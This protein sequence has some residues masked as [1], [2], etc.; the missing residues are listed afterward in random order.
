MDSSKYSSANASSPSAV[1]SRARQPSPP[2]SA[3]VD[4][5]RRSTR[6]AEVIILTKCPLDRSPY[7]PS[8]Y[9]TLHPKELSF[10]SR[11]R[12]N[13]RQASKLKTPPSV[14]DYFHLNSIM[15]AFCRRAPLIYLTPSR[16]P[17]DKKKWRKPFWEKRN[18]TF[19]RGTPSKKLIYEH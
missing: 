4:A 14:I 9:L 10:R 5:A 8:L 15:F 3:A 18:S 11:K 19:S 12:K 17:P 13:S 2:G 1:P 6:V 7:K 16:R